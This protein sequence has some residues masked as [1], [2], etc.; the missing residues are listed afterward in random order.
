MCVDK[1]IMAWIHTMKYILNNNAFNLDS[2]DEH[3]KKVDKTLS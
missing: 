2:L 3:I 1:S